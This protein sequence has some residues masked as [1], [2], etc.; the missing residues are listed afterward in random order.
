MSHI[1]MIIQDK[2]SSDFPCH[3]CGVPN[4]ASDGNCIVCGEALV[5][6]V[7]VPRDQLAISHGNAW[8]PLESFLGK[9]LCKDFSYTHSLDGGGVRIHVY[10]HRDTH[11]QLF[12]GED[13]TPYRFHDGAY[14]ETTTETALKHAFP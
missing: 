8:K 13:G 6:P 4:N 10:Y 7:R 12:L 1:A 11:G 5:P 14:E 3:W 9:D 2:T